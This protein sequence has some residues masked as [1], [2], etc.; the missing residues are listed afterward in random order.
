MISLGQSREMIEPPEGKASGAAT[1]VE[2]DNGIS[3]S[4]DEASLPITIGR[5]A[6]CDIHISSGHVS[7][8]HCELYVRDGRLFLRDTS[9]NGT[10][11]DDRLVKQSSVT[12]D[13]RTRVLLADE[14]KMVLTPHEG[15]PPGDGGSARSDRARGVDSRAEPQAAPARGALAPSASM[16]GASSQSAS[17]DASAPKNSERRRG[18][19]RRQR[20]IVV[21]FDRR[22]GASGRR[23]DS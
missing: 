23:S 21:A 6:S 15:T 16:H 22:S 1:R 18:A 9:S 20:N 19:D 14:I 10:T 12:I 2:L 5:D 3:F 7:R 8:Q 4:I 11:V 13:R 17:G